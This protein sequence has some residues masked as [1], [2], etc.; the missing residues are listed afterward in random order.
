MNK[1]Q[2]EL[3]I[4]S[5]LCFMT[6]GMGLYI[7]STEFKY[8]DLTTIILIKILGLTISFAGIIILNV[9]DILT[10]IDDVWLFSDEGLDFTASVIKWCFAIIIIFFTLF[11]SI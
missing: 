8:T 11:K 1:Y 6:I 10:N 9:R 7:S 5:I 3:L 4:V 2:K